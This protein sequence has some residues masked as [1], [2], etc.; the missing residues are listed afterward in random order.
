[1]QLM[2]LQPSSIQ[3]PNNNSV[4]ENHANR[5]TTN[6][7]LNLIQKYKY[8]ILIIILLFTIVA[9]TIDL[10]GYNKHSVFTLKHAPKQLMMENS[11]SLQVLDN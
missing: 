7:L 2:S 10:V 5:H 8:Y 3:I 11:S 4:Q 6:T 1:M 9:E